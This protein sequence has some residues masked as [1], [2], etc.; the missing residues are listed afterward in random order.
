MANSK[1]TD[2]EI[3]NLFD[4]YPPLN[5]GVPVE[6]KKTAIKDMVEVSKFGPMEVG[7]KDTGK[8]IRQMSKEN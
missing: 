6:L 3:S 1:I 8:K 2:E 4:K 5:D 7:T